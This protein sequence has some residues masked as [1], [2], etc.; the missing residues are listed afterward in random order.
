MAAEE[1]GRGE[2]SAHSAA[3]SFWTPPLTNTTTTT[4]DTTTTRLPPLR[5]W[6]GRS[7]CL[8]LP[9]Q[10]QQ[11]LLRSVV[12]VA[13]GRRV[14]ACCGGEGVKAPPRRGSLQREGT[15][16]CRL[17]LPLPSPAAVV[18]AVEASQGEAVH[19]CL[20]Q[21]RLRAIGAPAWLE[22]LPSRCQP[23]LHGG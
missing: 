8:P 16:R 5:Q 21:L 9:G 19:L 7:R 2:A 3:R 15:Q 4:T 22:A 14:A 20:R 12:R 17:A 6:A 1:E 23:R 11:L 18:A 10:L 13:T